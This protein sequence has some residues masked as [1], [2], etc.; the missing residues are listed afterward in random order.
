MAFLTQ[1][2]ME[3]GVDTF[4][5]FEPQRFA[6]KFSPPAI[7]MEYLVPSSGKL[8]MHNMRLKPQELKDMPEIIYLRLLRKHSVYLDPTKVSEAQ[9][10]GLIRRIIN[11]NKDF[12]K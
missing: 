3:F 12:K 1:G 8:Y 5:E 11:H 4:D 7:V 10:I 6:V 2:S 9:V